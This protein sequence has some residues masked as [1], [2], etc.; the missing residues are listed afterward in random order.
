MKYFKVSLVVVITIAM[1]TALRV[2]E[3]PL[4]V[5]AVVGIWLQTMV[6]LAL[7]AYWRRY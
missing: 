5:K 4:T 2:L 7:A 1:I 6:V 3:G